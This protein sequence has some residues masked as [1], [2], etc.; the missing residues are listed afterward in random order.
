MRRIKGLKPHLLFMPLKA[1]ILL[2]LRILRALLGPGVA[3]MG[4]V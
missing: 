4:E 3:L 2:K 1:H